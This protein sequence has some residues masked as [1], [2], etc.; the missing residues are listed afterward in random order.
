MQTCVTRRHTH[1]LIF[2]SRTTERSF[3]MRPQVSPHVTYFN[4]SLFDYVQFSWSPVASQQCAVVSECG[5]L[6]LGTLGRRLQA[7]TAHYSGV[8]CMAW[9]P[10]GQ[11]LV[12]GSGQQLYIYSIMQ[13]HAHRLTTDVK[14]QVGDMLF[15]C[16][17]G[18]P[19]L[20][21]HEALRVHEI[22]WS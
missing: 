18:E 19:W 12:A 6:L 14:V 3:H 22:V 16:F 9:S 13:Q 8:R 17:L 1:N 5:Q 10:N 15:V 2:K 21:L 11:M 4:F 7:N 20:R